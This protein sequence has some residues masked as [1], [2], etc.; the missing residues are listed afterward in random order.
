MQFSVNISKNQLMSIFAVSVKSVLLHIISLS[1]ALDRVQAALARLLASLLQIFLV[2]GFCWPELLCLL[3]LHHDL[4]LVLGLHLLDEVECSVL[5]FLGVIV[6][7]T[8][9]LSPPVI[10]LSV[11]GGGVHSVEENSEEFLVR[12][13]LGVEEHLH[14]LGVTR[15]SAT[16]IL[17][18]WM[19]AGT[20]SVTHHAAHHPWHSLEG[21]LDAPETSC[22]KGCSLRVLL[23][24]LILHWIMFFSDN[25][26]NLL[27]IESLH[28]S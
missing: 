20:S 21:Q 15:V 3:H 16:D 27:R 14:G 13:Q 19:L 11:E 10:A 8:P 1:V 6:D 5:L 25:L 4:V 17:V 26:L 2:V 28:W 23:G 24:N 22:S 12:D 7:T 18:G 9:V